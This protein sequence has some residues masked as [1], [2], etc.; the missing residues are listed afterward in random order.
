MKIAIEL[1]KF[2][3]AGD[4]RR[5][6]QGLRDNPAVSGFKGVGRQLYL[7]VVIG[8]LSQE[9]ITDLLALLWRYEI[10]LQPLAHLAEKERFAWLRDDRG[11]WYE[12]MF[13]EVI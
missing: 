12:S 4:E 3:S 7:S 5:F 11:Y 10:V 13:S 6:F 2:Y 8:R 1:A 9:A